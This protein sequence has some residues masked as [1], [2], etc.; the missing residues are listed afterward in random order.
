MFLV[1]FCK[2]IDW[3]ILSENPSD[4]VKLCKLPRAKLRLHMFHNGTVGSAKT[5]DTRKLCQLCKDYL[6]FD[7][8]H[9][10]RMR[11][12]LPRLASVGIGY[13]HV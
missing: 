3:R 1:V 13:R 12:H 7:R 10:S 9:D 5:R 6:H 2:N 8:L 11:C 4:R